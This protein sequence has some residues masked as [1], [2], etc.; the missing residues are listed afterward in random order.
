MMRKC[1]YGYVY[2]YGYGIAVRVWCLYGVCMWCVCGMYV[3]VC[4]C[5]MR[6]E[7]RVVT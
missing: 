5:M 4:L 2:G 3:D 7:K 6:G 1:G